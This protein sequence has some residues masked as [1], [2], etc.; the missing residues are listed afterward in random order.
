DRVQARRLLVVG[1]DD[2]PRGE[3]RIGVVEHDVAGARVVVPAFPGRQV[4]RTQLPLADGI[5]NPLLEPAF[6]LL[7]ADLQPHLD[8]DGPAIDEKLLDFRT[9]L[10]KALVLVFGA[11][12][13]DVLDARAVVPAAIEDDDLTRCR[14]PTHIALHVRLALLTV[15]RS[16][17]G[18]DS[19]YPGTH[20]LG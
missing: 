10:Q 20:A 3:L 11:E 16:R 1:S 17:Q 2:V 5:F 13:H 8:Q 19:E 12:T 6:L 7:V 18:D 14:E 9:Q 15:R 4:H